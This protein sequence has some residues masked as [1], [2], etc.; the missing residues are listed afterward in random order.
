MCAPLRCPFGGGRM[1]RI[2]AGLQRRNVHVYAGTVERHVIER[3]RA[4]NKAAK[5]S[6]KKNRG[7]K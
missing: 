6:R 2:L 5:A 4:K 3:R 1:N 7:K